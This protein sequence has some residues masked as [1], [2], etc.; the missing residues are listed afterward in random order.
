MKAKRLQQAKG[1]LTFI[2][3]PNA[4]RNRTLTVSLHKSSGTRG[5]CFLINKCCRYTHI[6]WKNS[7]K[8][9]S[10]KI[11]NGRFSRPVSKGG[12]SAFYFL[13]ESQ[14]SNF[15]LISRLLRLKN[16]VAWVRRSCL[17]I[18]HHSF[19]PPGFS[20]VGVVIYFC[21]FHIGES[22]KKKWY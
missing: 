9:K 22:W 1:S 13:C 3:I 6:N 12:N 10:L 16:V 17:E 20:V 4:T 15:I 18:S 8:T 11:C 19:F 5:Q 2:S 7:R 21:S 14:A